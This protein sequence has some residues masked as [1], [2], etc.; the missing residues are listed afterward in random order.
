M[1]DTPLTGLTASFKIT[2]DEIETLIGYISGVDLTLETEIVDILQ[3]GNAYKEKVPTIKDWSASVDGTAAF[4][5]DSTQNVLYD[6]YLAGTAIAVGI[7]LN[8]TTYFTGSCFIQ[9][10]KLTTSPDDKI[11]IACELSGSG[12][13]TLTIPDPED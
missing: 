9:S 5:A 8:N 10:L 11:S 3:F 2:V 6:A 1:A 13:L 7:Y 12:A 4:A